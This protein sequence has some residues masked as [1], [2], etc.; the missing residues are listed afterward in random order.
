MNNLKRAYQICKRCVMDTS[1]EDIQWD[2]NGIC[3]H[4]TH[5]I[6]ILAQ[7]RYNKDE[8][9]MN[10]KALFE[11]VKNKGKNKSYD[12]IIVISGGVDSCYMAYLAHSWG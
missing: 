4:C 9:A 3:N 6:Q 5:F 10:L 11:S 12:C 1:D 8:A 7:P 2:E